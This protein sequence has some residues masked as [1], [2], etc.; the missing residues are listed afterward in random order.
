[1]REA[2]APHPRGGPG[3]RQPSRGKVLH[4]LNR[5]PYGLTT[6]IGGQAIAVALAGTDGQPSVIGTDPRGREKSVQ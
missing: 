3:G 4:N 2:A 5:R 1:M 6:D